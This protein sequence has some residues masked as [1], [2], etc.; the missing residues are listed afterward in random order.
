MI[1]VVA[2]CY[3]YCIEISIIFWP[4]HGHRFRTRR[5]NSTYSSTVLELA[6]KSRIYDSTS[7][8]IIG[9]RKN[10][11]KIYVDCDAIQILCRSEHYRVPRSLQ[12][13]S[14]CRILQCTVTKVVFNATK[15]ES[16]KQ[17][18]PASMVLS[19]RFPPKC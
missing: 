12:N 6:L 10:G 14:L 8:A 13:E 3:K 5:T 18:K 11:W 17:R 15:R 2:K 16:A 4:N 9:R 19:S 1:L 7:D